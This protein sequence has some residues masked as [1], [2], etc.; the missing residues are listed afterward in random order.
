MFHWEENI[1]EDDRYEVLVAGGGVSGVAAALASAR[2]GR[3]VLLLEK[4][5]WLGGLSTSGL[6][7]FWVPLCNGRG[8]WVIRGMAEEFLKLSIQ[9]GPDTLP[10][11]WKYGEPSKPTLQRLTTKFSQG[12]FA[13]ALLKVLHDAGVTVLF[14]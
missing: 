8:K 9:Y 5:C 2:H 12:M 7:N 3:R 13:S 4:Q 6:V 1:V 10:D 14:A 11:D